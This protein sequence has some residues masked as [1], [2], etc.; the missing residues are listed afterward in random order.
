LAD[1]A[2][3][4]SKGNNLKPYV[5][6]CLDRYT[7]PRQSNHG[8]EAA[9]SGKPEGRSNA[10]RRIRR[11]ASPALADIRVTTSSSKN[12]HSH[13]FHQAKMQLGAVPRTL[14]LWNVFGWRALSLTIHL[15]HY[16]KQLHDPGHKQ[17]LV[18][19]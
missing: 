11:E 8:N 5:P 19:F 2:G 10:D 7:F 18:S 15:A 13:L 6:V 16:G 17:D 9:R 1:N 14:T 3:Y 4:S 12:V